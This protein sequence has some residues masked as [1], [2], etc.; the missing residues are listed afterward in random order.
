MLIDSSM[1]HDGLIARIN[2]DPQSHQRTLK[3]D[4][5]LYPEPI[6]A[7]VRERFQIVVTELSEFAVSGNVLELIDNQWAGNIDDGTMTKGELL[8]ALVGGSIY[9]RG[10]VNASRN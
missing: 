6:H 4:V 9:A 7:K 10:K 2:I 1:W 3:L 8:L 5:F